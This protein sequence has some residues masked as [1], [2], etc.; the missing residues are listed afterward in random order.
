MVGF[1]EEVVVVVVVVVIE[2]I[3]AVCWSCDGVERTSRSMC[4]VVARSVAICFFDFVAFGV[5]NGFNCR[6]VSSGVVG[7][8]GVDESC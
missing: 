3:G 1:L 7:V 5:C 2:A 4:V 6:L 8:V